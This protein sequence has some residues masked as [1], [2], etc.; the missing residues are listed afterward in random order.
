M[1]AKIWRAGL[2]RKD[3]GG[4]TIE[5]ERGLS[6]GEVTFLDEIYGALMNLSD[7]RRG[8]IVGSATGR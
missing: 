8:Y 5:D 1:D 3:A 6:V 2:R 7:D 4:E